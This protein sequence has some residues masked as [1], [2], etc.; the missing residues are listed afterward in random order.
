MQVG[1]SNGGAWWVLSLSP[2]YEYTELD[3]GDQGSAMG[4]FLPCKPHVGI[5]RF[6]YVA[7]FIRAENTFL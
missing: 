5:L 6:Y 3:K 7:Y 4:N 1:N 2:T